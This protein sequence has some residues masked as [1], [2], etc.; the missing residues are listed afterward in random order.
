MRSSAT[1]MPRGRTG[2]GW[3]DRSQLRDRGTPDEPAP[4]VAIGERD[5]PFVC[6][7]PT[8]LER[9]QRKLMTR[10]S[11]VPAVGARK[12]MISLVLLKLAEKKAVRPD[13]APRDPGRRSAGWRGRRR[14][15]R[16]SRRALRRRRRRRHDEH[17]ARRQ[18]SVEQPLG[19]RQVGRAVDART[20][21]DV[22]EARV[23]RD[24]VLV[25]RTLLEQLAARGRPPGGAAATAGCPPARAPRRSSSP[26]AGRCAGRR[27][28]PH[29]HRSG[30][31]GSRRSPE[32]RRAAA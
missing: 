5:Q 17:A 1:R 2:P 26:S 22:R 3:R 27:A 30:S 18:R 13:R 23:H 8:T 10:I 28:P 19:G 15:G 20:V 25:V 31:S 4:C 21:L 11:Y 7:H 32:G 12:S 9:A 29:A 6:A 14:T 16:P 24:V